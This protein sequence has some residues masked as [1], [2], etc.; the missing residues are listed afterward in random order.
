MVFSFVTPWWKPGRQTARPR[1]PRPRRRFRLQC[2]VLEERQL[3]S[4]WTVTTTADNGSNASPTPGSLRQAILKA[5]NMGAAS[6]K[7]VFAI[8]TTDPGYN[9]TTGAFTIQPP[10]AL[11]NVSTPVTIDG[12]T[13]PGAAVNTAA[14][15][16]NA[17]LKI[18][19][20]GAFL[21]GSENGLKITAGATTV[22]GLVI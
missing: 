4:T 9:P 18:V 21:S 10:T 17:Q 15:F 6:D 13:Q 19:L 11:P 1:P 20:N 16:D 3:L 14:A 12:Y 7:I 22:R 5:D 8:P 2:E